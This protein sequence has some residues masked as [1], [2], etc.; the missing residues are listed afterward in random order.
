MMHLEKLLLFFFSFESGDA[1]VVYFR[2][3]PSSPALQYIANR[4]FLFFFFEMKRMKS[5][6]RK[7]KT[8]ALQLPN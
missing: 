4:I 2:L 5:G 7:K 6:S 1:S 8:G 3:S